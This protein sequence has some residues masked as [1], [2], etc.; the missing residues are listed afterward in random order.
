M[1]QPKNRRFATEAYAEDNPKIASLEEKNTTQDGRLDAVV[2]RL[3][4]T[5]NIED[6]AFVVTDKDG[7][8]TWVSARASDGGP[9]DW[10]MR[11]LSD[12]LG[13]LSNQ[14]TEYLFGVVDEQERITDLAVR[15]SDGQIPDWVMDRWR[16]RLGLIQSV[17]TQGAGVSSPMVPILQSI[18]AGVERHVAGDPIQPAVVDFNTGTALD[19]PAK[20]FFPDRYNDVRPMPL[21]ISFMGIGSTVGSHWT[22]T[23]LRPKLIEAGALMGGGAYGGDLYGAPQMLASVRDLYEK[24]LRIAPVSGVVLFGNSMGG[25]GALNALTTGAIPNVLGVY[26]T[27]PTFDLRQRYD[28]SEGRATTIREAYGIATDGSDYDQKTAGYDP[29]LRPA[30]DFQGVPIRIY[31]STG[32][33]LWADHTVKL[34]EQL[35]ATNDVDV[36]DTGSE[37]HNTTD[38][39]NGTDLAAFVTK[40]VDGPTG[41]RL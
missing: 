14:D 13:V 7:K 39:F 41:L 8:E 4:E 1:V 30:A 31:S 37:G 26:L 15:A 29:A 2:G 5:E 11:H 34:V 12:R 38:R 33:T 3:P 6:L 18:A 28:S 20:I 21:V 32:D 24:A 10:T 16:E 17:D 27:D 35:S 19:Q 23:D 36:H 40:C 25:I 22:Y 9:T